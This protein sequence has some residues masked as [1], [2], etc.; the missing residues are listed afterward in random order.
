MVSYVYEHTYNSISG[1][2]NCQIETA[3]WNWAGF[4]AVLQNP[5]GSDLGSFLMIYKNLV[6]VF[7]IKNWSSKI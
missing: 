2:R 7:L 1:H 5:A 4:F 3:D 6:W